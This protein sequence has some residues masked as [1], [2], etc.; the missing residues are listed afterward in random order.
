MII[1]TQVY[2]V[3]PDIEVR[4]LKSRSNSPFIVQ[5]TDGSSVHMSLKDVQAL[6]LQLT[7]AMYEYDHDYE[8]N[9]DES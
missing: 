8:Y 7:A 4:L 2:N 5:F 1:S 3:T 9:V 6:Q